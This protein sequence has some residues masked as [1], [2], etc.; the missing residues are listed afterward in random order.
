MDTWNGARNA[1]T[2]GFSDHRTTMEDVFSA[3]I[4]LKYPLPIMCLIS[5]PLTKAQCFTYELG[6]FL[7]PKIKGQGFFYKATTQNFG[8]YVRTG[9]EKPWYNLQMMLN[10]QT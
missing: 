9:E 8:R 3:Q 1:G 6:C 2:Q 10:A 7:G 5:F 4:S